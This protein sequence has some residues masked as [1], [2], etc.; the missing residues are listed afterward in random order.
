MRSRLFSPPVLSTVD[1]RAQ[2]RGLSRT[3]LPPLTALSTPTTPLP[4][5]RARVRA[6]P[7][8]RWCVLHARSHGNRTHT[9]TR[10]R[11]RAHA[12]THARTHVRARAT[13]RAARRAQRE[14]EELKKLAAD[15]SA[16]FPTE[17]RSA[18]PQAIRLAFKR[19]EAEKAMVV[20]AAS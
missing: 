5:F 13:P 20:A 14:L 15:A 4:P 6:A 3:P 19:R 17:F 9:R 1:T 16:L 8:D 18:E 12:Y 7:V 2:T 11:A 10:A